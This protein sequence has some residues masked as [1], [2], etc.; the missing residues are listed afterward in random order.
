MIIPAALVAVDQHHV[1]AAGR[2]LARRQI[3]DVI[4]KDQPADFILLGRR[5]DF[6]PPHPSVMG[7][8]GMH[9]HL[10][11]VINQIAGLQWR[12]RKVRGSAKPR[13]DLGHF[14]LTHLR[15]GDNQRRT[16]ENE[17]G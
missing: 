4:R 3:R 15:A 13:R 10:T 1:I 16:A 6:I 14:C 7:K 8:R 2:K 9:M 12:I 11:A 5:E 17:G